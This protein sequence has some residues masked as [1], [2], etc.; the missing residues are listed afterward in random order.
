MEPP[1]YQCS[2]LG[3]K[4]GLSYYGDLAYVVGSAGA[5]N[6]LLVAIVPCICRTSGYDGRETSKG[7]GKRPVRDQ[8]KDSTLGLFEPDSMMA[9]FGQTAIKSIPID[10]KDFVNILQDQLVN[11]VTTLDPPPDLAG[12]D[13]ADLPII[14]GDCVYQFD[15]Q[16]F[17]R[18]LLLLPLLALGTVDIVTV[19]PSD[20]IISFAQS[21]INSPHI[22]N[23]CHNF[24]DH[25]E[26]VSVVV[27]TYT[28]WRTSS[29]ITVPHWLPHFNFN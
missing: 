18:G 2:I 19:P 12:F 1:A 22:N 7:K 14:S 27:T 15:G 25:A 9:R 11:Q 26:I 29:L 28:S 6:S 23:L 16:L 21:H 5:T 17:Y 20:E 13:W 10:K 3:P 24:I 4:K 8:E